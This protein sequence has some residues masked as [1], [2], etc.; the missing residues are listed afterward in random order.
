[1]FTYTYGRITMDDTL[2]TDALAL[3]VETEVE[4]VFI[5]VLSA[6]LSSRYSSY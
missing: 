3:A 5:W 2:G 6:L 1:M 4:N